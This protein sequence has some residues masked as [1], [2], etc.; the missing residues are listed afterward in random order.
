MLSVIEAK[1]QDWDTAQN[2]IR[3]WQEHGEQIVFT[4]GCFDLL[5][6]GHIHYLAQAR[7]LGNRLVV[8]LNSA[9][10]VRRL[11]GTNRPI[12]DEQTRLFTLASLQFIDL[13]VS[14]EEDTP[15]ELISTLL[16][17]ILVKG[18]DYTI[19]TIV[20]ADVVINN[21][22]AVKTLPFVEGYSTTSIE[23]KIRN[24]QS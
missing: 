3:Q 15:F 6:Y 12:N 4:N 21:G 9:S 2:T 10:S 19:E 5:H 14:F 24:Q 22:G 8:G 11:K 16:P 17:N 23:E 18:G 1:I 7:A 20:G 13:V